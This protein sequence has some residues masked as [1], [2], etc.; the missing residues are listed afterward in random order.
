[1]GSLVLGDMW[2]HAAATVARGISVC[3]L[4]RCTEYSLDVLFFLLIVVYSYN[5]CC[6]FVR[7]DG[8]LLCTMCANSVLGGPLN[9]LKVG[10]GGIQERVLLVQSMYTS[11]VSSGRSSGSSRPR[12]LVSRMCGN[13]GAH[14]S[15]L[16]GSGNR[17]ATLAFPLV[18]SS[19]E[20]Q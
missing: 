7:N 12:V 15:S 16:H 11:L 8:A 6:Y 19:G 10:G 13:L 2:M 14:L 17:K 5:Y 18:P 1:V 4:C 3:I 20:L 9:P